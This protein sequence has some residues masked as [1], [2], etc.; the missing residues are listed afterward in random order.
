M[1]FSLSPSW[2]HRKAALIK[3]INSAK[4]L[5]TKRRVQ[6]DDML[7]CFV[8]FILLMMYQIALSSVLAKP[9]SAKPAQVFTRITWH[10]AYTSCHFVSSVIQLTLSAAFWYHR[11]WAIGV[12]VSSWLS[13]GYRRMAS[14]ASWYIR[15]STPSTSATL[16]NARQAGQQDE[17]I[18][19]NWNL[20]KK[21]KK[22]YSL[23]VVFV[24]IDFIWP[25]WRIRCLV[26]GRLYVLH[27]SWIDLSW[28]QHSSC[29]VLHFS[30]LRFLK[31]S[32]C[33]SR[34]LSYGHKLTPKRH[35][36]LL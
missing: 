31:M 4:W 24:F 11:F 13:A 17:H 14:L 28:K 19:L 2:L 12:T 23:P 35:S 15:M 25:S 27:F 36:E 3:R 5:N 33:I 8:L 1:L 22:T 32:S 6:R 18:S 20:F 10:K 26:S 21:K 7:R 16:K 30:V 29:S 34:V 9:L